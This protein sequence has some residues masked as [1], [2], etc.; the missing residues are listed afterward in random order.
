MGAVTGGEADVH[1]E[2]SVSAVAKGPKAA[3]SGEERKRVPQ[4]CL[5]CSLSGWWNLG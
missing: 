5:N 2:G 1:K 3:C 4:L